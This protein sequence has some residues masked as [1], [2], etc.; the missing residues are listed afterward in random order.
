M[1]EEMWRH[2]Y[3]YI[4]TRSSGRALHEELNKSFFLERSMYLHLFPLNYIDAI[5]LSRQNGID[6]P[7]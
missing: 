3:L 4:E 6:V 7:L 5:L 1:S 2:R